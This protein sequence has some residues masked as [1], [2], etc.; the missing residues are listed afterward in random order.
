M[1]LEKLN[2]LAEVDAERWFSQSC[3]AQKWIGAMVKQ[4]P[5]GSLQEVVS[6][7][8]EAWQTCTA[9]DYMQAFKAH[10]MIGNVN[11]LRAKFSSTKT[12][13]SKEQS[14]AND[15][16]ELTLKEL[17]ELNHQYLQL[18]GFI[19]II[20]ASGLTAQAMLQALKLRISNK[21]SVELE[22]A[23]AEQIKITLLRLQKG[24]TENS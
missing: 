21:Q 6:S 3:A 5:Y 12:L 22:K 20:C 15:A 4:R 23:A 17:S 18:N 11:S 16:S 24:L 8:Q 7:A 9:K 19:F 14:G 1:N 10:P 13:A 2:S